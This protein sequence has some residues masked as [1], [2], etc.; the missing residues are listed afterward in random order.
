MFHPAGFYFDLGTQSSVYI[1]MQTSDVNSR[2]P[3]RN[4]CVQAAIS[5]AEMTYFKFVYYRTFQ[6][7]C[8]GS[9]N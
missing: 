7:F 3:V 1:I 4:G 6:V 8:D 9:M 2:P 5:L